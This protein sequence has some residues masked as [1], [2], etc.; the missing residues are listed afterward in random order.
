M[1]KITVNV[2]EYFNKLRPLE[3]SDMECILIKYLQESGI[4]NFDTMRR[5]FDEFHEFINNVNKKRS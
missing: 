5:F 3:D 1:I 2:P 4:K